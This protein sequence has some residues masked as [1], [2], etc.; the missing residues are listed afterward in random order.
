MK[1][2]TPAEITA[3]SGAELNEAVARADGWTMLPDGEWQYYFS[4]SVLDFQVQATVPD[5]TSG[6]LIDRMA[7]EARIGIMSLY[8]T[9][10]ETG[11]IIGMRYRAITASQV[12]WSES[13]T[14][15]IQRAWLWWR[16]EKG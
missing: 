4:K 14:T 12:F 11:T 13:L 16:Q 6:D 8:K 10:R 3:L 2:R 7:S 5:Y 1:T 15:A 9:H